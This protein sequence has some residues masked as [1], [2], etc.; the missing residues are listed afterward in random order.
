L[1]S[2]SDIDAALQIGRPRNLSLHQVATNYDVFYGLPPHSA[3]MKFLS[4]A[5]QLFKVENIT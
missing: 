5:K 3:K 4:H 2:Y 1:K